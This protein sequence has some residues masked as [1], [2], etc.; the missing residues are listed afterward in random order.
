MAALNYYQLSLPPP[1]PARDTY[2][3]E[4]AKRGSGVFN[5]K[6][7]CARCHVPPLYVEPGWPMHTAQEIG[8]DDFQ[9]SRS[10]EKRYYRTTPL[11]GLFTRQKGGYYHDGRFAKLDDVVTHYSGVLGLQLSEGERKD[12]IEFLKSL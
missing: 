2:D 10:P 9:A 7:A 4:A 5:G 12:L 8:I 6:A 3:P 1:K 11:G